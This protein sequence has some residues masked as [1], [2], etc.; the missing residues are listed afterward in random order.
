M[1]GRG[2]VSIALAGE[3]DEDPLLLLLSLPGPR[4]EF[5]LEVLFGNFTSAK[6]V[7]PWDFKPSI[8]TF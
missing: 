6:I 3:A 4:L 5:F 2:R 8:G 1:D 7:Y